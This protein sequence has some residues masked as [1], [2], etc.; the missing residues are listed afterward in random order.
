MHRPLIAACAALALAACAT[1]TVYGP[2]NPNGSMASQV[3][4][5]EYKIENNR[6]RV[7]F[8]GGSGAP[9]RQ[10]VDYALLR[11]AEI[12]IRD[13][14]DWFHVVN[15]FGGPSKLGSNSRMSVGT[16]TGS[17]GRNTSV[18]IGVGTS[19]DLSGGPAYSHT[20]EVIVGSGEKPDGPEVY[21]ARALA[22]ALA[23]HAP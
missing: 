8:Q 14:H 15:Q 11:A 6:Y 5:S 2:A 20:L 16:G 10:V 18:G 9:Q 3:G 21:D 12:T 1:P 23:P 22:A 4:Y 19:F 13:G 17:Y 7:S